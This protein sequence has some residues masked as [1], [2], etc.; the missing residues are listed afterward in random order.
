MEELFSNIN[1]VEIIT[2][3]IAIASFVTSILLNK[4]EIDAD[5]ISKARIEWIQNV[6]QVVSKILVIYYDILKIVDSGNNDDLYKIEDLLMSAKEETEL[7][8]LYFGPDSSTKKFVSH[9]NTNE[10]ILTNETS[11]AMKNDYIVKFLMDLYE[12]FEKR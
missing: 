12:R 2:V 6:R 11:N 10:E 1:I 9:T 5:L 8:I 7:L 4:R 3:I